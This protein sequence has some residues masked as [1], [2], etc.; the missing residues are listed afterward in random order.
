[1]KNNTPFSPLLLFLLFCLLTSSPIFSQNTNLSNGLAFDGEPFLTVNPT[2]PHHF[3]VAWMGF[4]LGNNLVIKTTVSTD[5]GLSWSTPIGVPHTQSGHTSADPSLRWDHQGNLFLCWIDY[6]RNT[7]ATGTIEVVKSTDGGLTWGAPAEVISLTDCPGKYCIDRP[8]MVIDTTAGSNQGNIYVTSMNAEPALGNPPYNPYFTRS[9][10]GGT[11]FDTPQFLDTTG[12]LAGSLINKPMP[13]PAVTPNGTFHAIYP[14]YETSQNLFPQYILAS[15]TNGGTSFTYSTAEVQTTQGA[16]D[17]L[18]KKG[19]LL[20]ADPTN[21]DHL[22]NLSVRGPNGDLDILMTE[23]TDGGQ[24]WSSPERINDDPI[25]NGVLQD[26]VWGAFDTDGDLVVC[27]RDRRNASGTGY[28]QATEMYAAVRWADSS[29]FEA[30]VPISST[31]A[32]FDVVLNEAGNDFMGVV[33]VDDTLS[34]AWGDVRTGTLSIWFTRM[35]MRDGMSATYPVISEPSPQEIAYPNPTSGML[36]LKEVEKPYQYQVVD[37]NGRTVVESA[38]T[39]EE[40]I[41]L[42]GLKSGLYFL[43]WSDNKSNGVI[44]V[45]KE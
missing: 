27:W 2:D 13:T 30:N 3:V 37:L 10:N 12:W 29:G 41:N 19:Y 6:N 14:S 32:A 36:K 25:G 21:S 31:D 11:S 16:N 39:Y 9:T 38:V 45:M 35:S 34:A 17:S 40:E 24:N 7:F 8:W 4:Q 15:S 5:A 44:R 42:S 33:F 20:L 22:V 43:E 18:A 23:T 1:M 26:M 28:Q